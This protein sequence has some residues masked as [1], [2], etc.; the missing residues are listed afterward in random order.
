LELLIVIVLM[1]LIFSMTTPLFAKTLAS[2]RLKSDA[3]QVASLLRLARQAAISSGQGKMV[4][5]YP[6]NAKYK[7]VGQTPYNLESGISFVGTTTFTTRVGGLP[8]CGFS[9]SGAPSSGGTITLGN[10][11]NRL[12]VIVNPV[13]GRVRIS[14]SP[15]DNW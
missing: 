3:R 8:A 5:F 1:G 15:P 7:I 11:D 6:N 10:S 14:T 4:V 13:A 9:P 2:V 12:Y